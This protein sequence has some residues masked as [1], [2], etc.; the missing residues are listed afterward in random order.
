MKSSY[1]AAKVNRFRARPKGIIQAGSGADY[2]IQSE[3]DYFYMIEL[4]RHLF[5]NDQIVG[6]GVET[7]VA[8]VIQEGFDVDPE[9]GDPDVDSEL[10]DRFNA[11]AIDPQ[12][13]DWEGEKT[14]CEQQEIACIAAIRDGD[15]FAN[16]LRDGSLQYFEAHRCRTPQG[17]AI[18]G[19]RWIIHGVEKNLTG[20]RARY[21]ITKNEVDGFRFTFPKN[22][23]VAF[24]AYVKDPLTARNERGIIH[25]Y[26]GKSFSQSRGVPKLIRVTTTAGMHDDVQFATLVKQQVAACLTFIRE[27]P[28]GVQT[29]PQPD[30][31]LFDDPY[32]TTGGQQRLRRL[33]PG[34]EYASRVPGETIKGFT[35]GIPSNEFMNHSRM[36]LTFIAVNLDLP[37]I[38]LLMDAGETNF[39]GWRGAMDQAKLKF[40]KFQKRFAEKYHNEVYRWKVRQFIRESATLRA[41]YG[42]MGE[43]IFACRW[44][45]PQWPYIEPLK[46]ASADLLIMR[47]GLSSPR[48]VLKGRNLEHEDVARE[49]CEDN[50]LVVRYAMDKAME[51]NQHP[52]VAQNESERVSWREIARAPLA[53]GFQ[54]SIT[55]TAPMQQPAED[56]AGDTENGE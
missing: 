52:L 11:W 29:M 28:L 37:L 40:R 33:S 9:T 13:C 51:L 15:I 4:S 49:T 47:N 32:S 23:M 5:N 34:A 17:Q 30:T 8:N 36:L 45:F 27:L 1:E 14:W 31:E 10:K 41:A 16:P 48:R 56:E 2:H 35:P 38:L 55:P 42:R 20:R 6:Q 54:L 43:E 22:D 21:W 19:D 12:Q 3:L 25:T 53:D 7:L 26:F 39:S 24:P 18:S 50:A 44:N 46:D